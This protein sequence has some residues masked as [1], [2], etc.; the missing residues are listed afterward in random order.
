MRGRI[1]YTFRKII[2]ETLSDV[3][4]APAAPADYRPVWP[5]PERTCI[6]PIRRRPHADHLYIIR[7]ISATRTAPLFGPVRPYL[8]PSQGRKATGR[9]TPA[10]IPPAAAGSAGCAYR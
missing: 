1:F 8:P 6:A 4:T 10:P 9:A 2:P 7:R 3:P 5:E